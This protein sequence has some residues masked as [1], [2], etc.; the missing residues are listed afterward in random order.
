MDFKERTALILA[1]LR[2][3]EENYPSPYGTKV[4]AIRTLIINN[5]KVSILDSDI[6]YLFDKGYIEPWYTPPDGKKWP[7]MYG[8]DYLIKITSKGIDYLEEVKSQEQPAQ[9]L[10]KNIQVIHSN[11]ANVS[12]SGD[13]YA[14]TNISDAFK[15]VYVQRVNAN[16][17]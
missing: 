6:K 12:Q 15:Q 4:S 5:H 7:Y 8:W 14:I 9:Y 3:I 10:Q 17:S 11:V 1:Y 16:F 2:Y 13:V